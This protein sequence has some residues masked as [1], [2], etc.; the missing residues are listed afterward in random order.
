M[1]RSFLG[2]GIGAGAGVGF[3]VTRFTSRAG[4]SRPAAGGTPDARCDNVAK[5]QGIGWAGS[6]GPQVLLAV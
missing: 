4:G 6:N 2:G 1:I 3:L 5:V